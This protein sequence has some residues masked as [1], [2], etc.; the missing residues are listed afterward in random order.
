MNVLSTFN[1]MGCIWIALD[2]IGV[3]VGKR[4][5]CEI[6]KYANIVN[7]K[8]YRDTI[9]LGDVTKVKAPYLKPIDLLVGGSPCQGFS[10]AGKQLN[11]DDPRSKLFFEF[12]RLLDECRK[13]NPQ[14]KFLL[15]NVKMK[16]EFQQIITD[17]LGVEPIEINS[18]LVSAQNRRRL[19]WTNIEG[20]KQ[21]EDKGILLKDIL[22]TEV[23]EKYYLSDKMIN[24]FL[25]K[26]GDFGQRFKPIPE[27]AADIKSNCLTPGMHKMRITDNYLK[28]NKK[29]AIK[30]DQ[31]KAP[32]LTGGGHSGGNHSDMDV[33]CVAMRGRN[34]ENPSDRTAGA[35][36]E[37]RLEPKKDGKT[38]CLTSV[39]KDNLLLSKSDQRLVKN[40]RGHE[41]KGQCLLSTSH[42]GSW[43]NGM[44]N[45][46]EGYRLRRLTPLECERLQTVP[47]RYSDCV[48]NTQR[49]KMLGNG[50]TVDVIA[51]ILKNI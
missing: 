43:A 4:Y 6:D 25:T 13:I 21:P 12:V 8:N 26:G 32:C 49:Y 40:I 47:D 34:P 37:Q 20:V 30:R 48:S 15:E 45:I 42:K 10:F 33:L 3:K 23:D 50:W 16:K 19:Y 51:H 46:V 35:K 9:Q 2:R 29:G 44:T 38:N 18:A 1:G 27:E 5:S 39:T 14:V 36:T 28:I 11:F 24:G 31:N 22:E 7:D 17:A 41:E